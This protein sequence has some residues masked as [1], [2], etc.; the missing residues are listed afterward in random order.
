MLKGKDEKLLAIFKHYMITSYEDA[1][2]IIY[3][4]PLECQVIST[5]PVFVISDGFHKV[6][7]E[8]TKEAIISMKQYYPTIRPTDLDKR[9]ITLIEYM[10]LTY[11]DK[12]L[13]PTLHIYDFYLDSVEESKRPNITGKP[14]EITKNQEI[15][16]GMGFETQKHIR[17]YLWESYPFEILPPLEK[18]LLRKQ[19]EQNT[20]AIKCEGKKKGRKDKAGRVTYEAEALEEMDDSLTEAAGRLNVKKKEDKRKDKDAARK[21]FKG[22]KGK[23]RSL[24]K[25]LVKWAKDLKEKRGKSGMEK[26][27]D[28]VKEGVARVIARNIGDPIRI[29]LKS[30]SKSSINKSIN[31]KKGNTSEV[32]FDAKGFRNFMSWNKKAGGRDIESNDVGDVL[33]KGG[34]GPIEVDFAVPSQPS[35]RAFGGWITS[36]S[37][38]KRKASDGTNSCK[39]STAK[40]PKL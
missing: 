27:P 21:L 38:K 17:R 28:F 1:V 22:R 26:S 19:I 39:K 35:K 36:D 40:K 33:R 7:C 24:E 8:F 25:D 10:P 9:V 23:P 2:A 16:R 31:S 5:G 14:K 29:N 12:K 32:K 4:T 15:Q 34:Q 37:A 11:F 30:A 3:N 18:I 6:S 20:K 13:S